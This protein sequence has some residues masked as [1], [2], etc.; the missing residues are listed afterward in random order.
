MARDKTVYTCTACGGTSAK[1]LGKCPHCGEW[2]TLEE[3]VADNNSSA[4]RHRYKAIA[5]MQPVATLS[6][7]EASEVERTPTG[8]TELDRALGGGIVEGG[9][10]LIGGDPG[11]GKSTLLLQAAERLAQSMPVLYV[12]GEESGAQ[13]ALRARRLGLREAPV[14]VLAEIQLERILAA[15]ETERP[16]FCVIDSIQTVFSDA[17]T[18]APGSVAQVREC[19][20]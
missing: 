18:S 15:I 17:L 12:T 2:N 4:P 8:L 13:V 14:R 19:A 5:P 20:A 10:V 16:K 3:G 6:E 1:W 7:I 11:I 9:V